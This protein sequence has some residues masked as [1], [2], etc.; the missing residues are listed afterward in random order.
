MPF[1]NVRSA[2]IELFFNNSD[3]IILKIISRRCPGVRDER[4]G[5]LQ[6]YEPGCGNQG[7]ADYEHG[8]DIGNERGR[9]QTPMPAS[10]GFDF[11]CFLQ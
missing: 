5:E 6:L 9:A 4:F 3:R 8:P 10:A 1:S 11:R 2:T 7:G